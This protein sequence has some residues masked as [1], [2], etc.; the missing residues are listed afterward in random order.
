[1][2]GLG[3]AA[4]VGFIGLFKGQRFVQQGAEMVALQEGGDGDGDGALGFEA[5]VAGVGVD[6]VVAAE[7]RPP[8]GPVLA[9]VRDGV[10]DPGWIAELGYRRLADMDA[11]LP[12][13]TYGVAVTGRNDG[14][15]LVS[16][17]LSGGVYPPVPRISN[18]VSLQSADAGSP[19]AVQWEAMT[20]GTVNDYMRL[21]IADGEGSEVYASAGPGGVGALNGTSVEWVV[22]AGV[23]QAGTDYR[24]ELLWVKV[25]DVDTSYALAVA[26]YTKQV[27][28][29]MRTAPRA[30]VALGAELERVVPAVGSGDVGRD[31]AV[32]FHFSH[33]MDPAARSVAWSGS[34]VDPAKFLYQWL[35]GNRVLWCKYNG[36]LPG[37]V[38]VRWDMNLGGFRDAAG[39]ALT[40]S[41]NGSFWTR[42]EPPESPPDVQGYYVVKARE[43]VQVG[44]VAVATGMY[45]CELGIDLTAHNRVKE[46]AGVRFGGSGP[47]AR[48]QHDAWDAEMVYD[49]VYA[50]K[51][52]L[53]RFCPNGLVAFQF[54]A[55]LDGAKSLELSTGEPDVYP[56]AP[57]VVNLDGLQALD[58]GQP[59]TLQWAALPG[60]D[61][62][63]GLGAGIMELEVETDQ[64][65]GVLWVDNEEFASGDRFTLPA[66]VLAPGRTYHCTLH[67][68][69]LTGMNDR[70]GQWGG[71][72]GFRSLTDFTIRTAG[73]PDLPEL[74]V[75][76]DAD[77]S[78]LGILGGEGGRS[79]VL[80]TSR[81][82]GRWLPFAEWWQGEGQPIPGFDDPDARYLRARYYRVRDRVEG[83]WVQRR[84]TLQGTVWEDSTRSKWAAGAIVGTSLDGQTVATDAQGRFFLETDAMGTLGDT[85][86][87][88]RIS[89]G[90]S[91]R[92]LGPT[93]WG[94]QPRAL[95]LVFGQ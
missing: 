1:M 93:A 83:E 45:G 89:Y 48:L 54:T 55:A 23:L 28:F 59:V 33:A 4:D 65:N 42:I 17:D 58:P 38:E 15:K 22:P 34:G 20:G 68:T 86:Y 79:Y 82:L 56:D 18:Y 70:Y 32:A 63:P 43:H 19:V 61:P 77:G 27:A 74:V 92:E 75:L 88:I 81:D 24:A 31:A 40:G 67:F 62:Q 26:G 14:L 90:G 11:A 64:G 36:V 10:G 41:R 5:L 76:H 9:M 51:A 78:Y 87:L 3:L 71:M 30:G 60:W 25:A 49:A 53:D 50:S 52:D 73:S 12:D 72:A 84:V 2:G 21:S 95:D 46:P 69:R 8:V 94:D 44:G 13:G 7:V 35:D 6:S 85:P 37:G 57:V 66:G 39:F 29:R 16:L 91:T 47:S 80:E